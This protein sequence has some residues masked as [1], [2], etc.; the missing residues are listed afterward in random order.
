MPENDKHKI[1]DIKRHLYD[2]EDT[3]THRMHEGVLHQV[4]HDA[5]TA[6]QAPPQT[7]N[8]DSMTRPKKPRTSFFKKF[9]IA[10]ILFFIAA[11][12]FAFFMYEQ[13]G[14]SVSNDNIDISV[15]GNAFT[16]GGDE[17]PLQIEIVN[18]NNAK[19]ELADLLI[20]YPRGTGGSVTD[21]VRLPRDT[22]GTI[23]AG[24]TVTRN[25]K[26]SLYGDEQSAQNIKISLQYHPE[27]SNAIFTK[28]KD[29][30]V[31]ISSAPLSLLLDAPDTATSNQ[32]IVLKITATL[33]TTVPQDSTM[34]QVS[35]P[36][37]FVFENATP[38]PKFGSTVWSLASLTQASP[39]TI[40]VSGHLV[41]QDGDQQ[42]FHVY[43]GTTTPT[44]Q[45]TINVVYNSLLKNMTIAKPFLETHILV[46][47]QDLPTYTA[48]GGES[49]HAD[50]SWVNNLPTRITDAQIILSLSGNAYDRSTINAQE[51]FFDSA[52]NQIIWDKNTTPTLASVEPGGIGSVGFNFKPVSLIGI[53]PTIIDPQ[54]VLNVSIKGRQP[55]IGSTFSDVNNFIK[56]VIKIQSDFQIASSA[57]YLTGSMPPKAETETKY[58]VTWTLSNSANSI[59]QAQARATLPIYVKWVASSSAGT[60]DV[61][62]NATTREVIWNIGTVRPN[63]G[64][65]SNR[66][67]SFVLAL[68]P[69]TS[70]V[71]SVPQLM[72]DVFLSGQDSFAGILLKSSRGPI[73]T[74]LVSDP[75]FKYGNERVVR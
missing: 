5:P 48:E 9:F 3:T 17:L 27:G 49:V 61:T 53:N 26:V 22:I 11:L 56:K 52:N 31:T 68:S 20:E 1:E 66:E 12:G 38:A 7:N 67:A 24:E 36:S 8:N 69:S 30:P 46:N 16:K 63:T 19:L 35:Y 21:V 33:N 32:P 62:Y 6:W 18:H 23:N 51:G 25:I 72:K 70:Q 50:I 74:L 41:G 29:Y 13:G 4:R 57:R 75:N 43:A 28:E 55:S 71:G 14:V 40:L 73:T 39:V 45:S 64:F 65:N 10:A 15:L 58:T 2:R 34:L 47:S 42:V 44:N 54:I 59:V 60:E 37:G